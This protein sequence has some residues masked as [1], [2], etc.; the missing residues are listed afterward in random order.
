MSKIH[1]L[2]EGRVE[3]RFKDG[4]IVVIDAQTV[5]RPAAGNVDYLVLEN[6]EKV[7][8]EYVMQD[9]AGWRQLKSARSQ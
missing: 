3:I 9:V 5:R 6:N 1:E 8:A 2:P 4:N 7:V